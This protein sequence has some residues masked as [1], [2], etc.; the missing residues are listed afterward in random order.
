MSKNLGSEDE[1]VIIG[2]DILLRKA[3]RY[4]CVCIECSGK[5]TNY[6]V[7]EDYRSLSE[8]GRYFKVRSGKKCCGFSI[9]YISWNT[10][11]KKKF[12]LFSKDKREV[13]NGVT[14]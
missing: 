8:E 1:K 5:R 3:Q 2:W 14:T 7:P 9:S 13:L 10:T 6:S 11:V 12:F 4:K